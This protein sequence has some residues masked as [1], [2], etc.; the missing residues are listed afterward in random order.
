MAPPV[1]ERVPVASVARHAEDHL[2]FIRRAMERSST[3]TAVPGVGGVGMGAIGVAAA[4]LGRSQPSAERWLIV[5]L[6]AAVVALGIGGTTMWR[7]AARS[8][9]P[10]VGA[11][12]RRFAL[13][14]SAPLVAGA[15]IT[16]ALWQAGDYAVM[17]ATWL[18]LYGAGVVTGGM[19]SAPVVRTTGVCFM[20][21]GLAAIVAPQDWGTGL[22]AIGFGGLHIGFGI[23]IARHHGG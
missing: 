10:L 17:P 3:F 19:F 13:G 5:W 4:V 20:A 6:V 16:Y 15:S 2:E 12:G 1:G 7:K 23:H 18:L 11:V 22:L 8:G 21:V 14:M 9:A